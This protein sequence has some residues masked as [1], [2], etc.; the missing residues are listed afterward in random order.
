MTRYW[1]A[2]AAA[3][4]LMSGV[5]FAQSSST[6][7]TTT[8]TTPTPPVGSY[9]SE[10]RHTVD[11]NGV[12]TDKSMSYRAGPTGSK[13]T[14]ASRTVAP[15]GSVQSNVKVRR[16]DALGGSST[17]ERQTTTTNGQ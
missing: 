5:A 11:E 4:A 14:S 15:D 10:T 16:D 3:L 7:S 2:G 1:L 9:S 17:Y 8:V 12:T 13:E 6:E